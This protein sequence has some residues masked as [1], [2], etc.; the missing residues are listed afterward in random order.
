MNYQAEIRIYPSEIVPFSEVE[1]GMMFFPY[2]PE[3]SILD[4][5]DLPRWK[6]P[7]ISTKISKDK[8]YDLGTYLTTAFNGTEQVVLVFLGNLN[9]PPLP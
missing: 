4:D 5:R 2:D 9:L 1:V 3:R 6:N 7:N 8:A